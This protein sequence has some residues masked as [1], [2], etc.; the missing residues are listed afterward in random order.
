MKERRTNSKLAEALAKAK[1]A[2]AA[3]VVC[4]T[5]AWCFDRSYRNR[6]QVFAQFK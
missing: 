2:K 4:G 5:D 1:K 6:M 3:V